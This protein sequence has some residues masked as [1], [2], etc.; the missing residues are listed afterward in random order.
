MAEKFADIIKLDASPTPSTPLLTVTEA[1]STKEYTDIRIAPVAPRE[2][3]SLTVSDDKAEVS[4]NNSGALT[5]TQRFTQSVSSTL[6]SVANMV[7]L[8]NPFGLDTGAK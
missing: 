8:L 4:S 1:P 6:T 2:N 5:P 3:G 7:R